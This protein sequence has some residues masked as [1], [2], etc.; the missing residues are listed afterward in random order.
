M[1]ILL[2]CSV[3][4]CKD[5]KDLN[6]SWIIVDSQN[7]FQKE[8]T[9]YE[10]GTPPGNI[11]LSF[12]DG[13]YKFLNSGFGVN[14][15][16]F[17]GMIQVKKNS[18]LF[19][20]SED[21]SELKQLNSNIIEIHSTNYI[22]YQNIETFRRIDD[23]LK[24]KAVDFSLTDKKYSRKFQSFTDTVHFLNDSIYTS[25]SWAHGG[26]NNFDYHRFQHNGFDI[27]FTD[28]YPPFI[29]KNIIKDTIYISTFSKEKE[30]Y[31]MT[32]VLDNN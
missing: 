17:E 11:I 30:D 23:S 4:S 15:E 2:I 18:F 8:N 10:V 25:N 28:K 9:F 32:E 27:L 29:I 1:Y 3:F 13:N 12:D 14:P 31:I 24:H 19:G 22:G 7:E 16:Q 5:V 26:D 6:G 20:D 21:S